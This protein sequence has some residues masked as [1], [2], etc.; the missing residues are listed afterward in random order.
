VYARES[1]QIH[2]LGFPER[3]G[4][5]EGLLHLLRDQDLVAFGRAA[6][7][8]T[9]S[10]SWSSASDTIEVEIKAHRD[11]AQKYRV[12]FETLGWGADLLR[13]FDHYF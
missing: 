11:F 4:A 12:G 2:R 5:T 1:F 3:K 7:A 10:I 13:F 9:G 8:V 6:S